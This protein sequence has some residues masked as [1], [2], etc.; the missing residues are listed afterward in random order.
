MQP[1]QTEASP[2]RDGLR[3]NAVVRLAVMAPCLF[4]WLIGFA[5][6]AKPAVRRMAPAGSFLG[7]SAQLGQALVY[8]AIALALYRILIRTFERRPTVELASSPGTRLAVI[9]F[10]IGITLCCSVVG[11]LCL[12]GAARVDGLGDRSQF[13]AQLSAATIAAVGEELLFRGVLFRILEQATG[14][15]C[16]LLSSALIFG[17]THLLNPEATLFS[18]LAIAI[19]AGLLLGLA[20]VSTRNLWFPI[21]IHLAWNFT[22]GGIFDAAGA[23]TAS[24]SLFAL[25]LSGPDWLTGG[26]MGTN[27]SAVTVV[28]CLAL[29]GGFAGLAGKR[30]R[31]KCRRWRLQLD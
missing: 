2:L 29:S 28:L 9:G 4:G 22:Q 6:L 30:G 5:I 25:I 27:D 15:L 23:G 20:F 31:L 3:R 7:D 17:L 13:I 18:S 12:A 19:E 26:S 14:T 21:G 11:V 10:L 8:V 24:H 1:I 16:A